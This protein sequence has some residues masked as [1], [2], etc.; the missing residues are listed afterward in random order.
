MKIEQTVTITLTHEQYTVLLNI[1]DRFDNHVIS[2][3]L[4]DEYQQES[5]F[6][7]DFNNS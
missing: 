4:Q 1:L 6:I 3:E 7:R 5:E 2:D